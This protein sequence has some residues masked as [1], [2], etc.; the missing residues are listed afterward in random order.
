MQ[1]MLK[2]AYDQIKQQMFD[3]ASQP[4]VPA[5]AEESVLD[6]ARTV[7]AQ[8]ETAAI[9]ERDKVRTD[10]E[11]T[12]NHNAELEKRQ[13]AADDAERDARDKRERA[14]EA[15]A[16]VESLGKQVAEA[17]SELA[18]ANRAHEGDQ[19]SADGNQ[20]A[21]EGDQQVAEA[22]QQAPEGNRQAPELSAL[23]EHANNLETELG[24]AEAAAKKMEDSADGAES[25]A[26]AARG[27]APTESEYLP[28]REEP[29]AGG[30]VALVAT[31]E[32]K[33][34]RQSGRYSVD[35]NKF[36]TDTKNLPFEA[37]IGDLRAF[38][39]DPA[40][41]RH[42]NL[43]DPLYRQ[44]EIAVFVDGLNAE[45]FGQYIN[46]VTVQMRKRH[47]G[48][49]LTLEEVR[50]DRRN[51]NQQGNR[52]A[53]LYGWK[54]DKALDR[55]FEYEYR[56]VW[57]FFGG[58]SVEG[59]WKSSTAE[60]LHAA[61]PIQRTNVE[62]QGDPEA[63]QKAG[64]R[65][66]TVRVFYTL[67]GVEKVKTVTLNAMKNQLSEKIEFMLPEGSPEYA[68]EIIW[69]LTGNRTVS[70]GRRL[71]STAVLFIDDIPAS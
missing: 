53:L 10:N 57:S 54:N 11:T 19:Q 45:D 28:V 48:G 8:N 41:F 43:D 65:A 34:T 64:V 42:V 58:I 14:D 66:V 6:R 23:E 70:S 20:Q 30:G 32:M 5:A 1:Q 61:P 40:H 25:A 59:P 67:A 12:R 49:D 56:L 7:F 35:L 60:A 4:A 38:I 16:H 39:N 27:N 31:F 37:N 29:S 71:A 17:K 33:K 9:T 51:F 18:K 26:A 68:Y 3:E 21:A 50:I 15:R 22:S 47:A 44:R 63:I 13:R 46:F 52:F 2:D 36:T 62:V 24:E 69:Q 55:W